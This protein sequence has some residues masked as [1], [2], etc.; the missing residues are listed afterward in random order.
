MWR[1]AIRRVSGNAVRSAGV[2]VVLAVGLSACD[3]GTVAVGVSPTAPGNAAIVTASLNVAAAPGS[4]FGGSACLASAGASFNFVIAARQR[5]DFDSMTIRM[6]DGTNL[7]GP[8]ITVPHAQLVNEFGTTLIGAGT[9]RSFG[10]RRDIPCDRLAT[11]RS[12]G[13]E[14]AFVDAGGQSHGVTV[15]TPLP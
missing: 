14:L 6:V 3:G 4:H 13:A 5:V 7:G 12:I 2:I 8:M 10:L 15:S 1:N 11:A 9:T